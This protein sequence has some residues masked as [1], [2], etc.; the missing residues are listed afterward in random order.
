MTA[1]E[2][3]SRGPS[4][5]RLEP[6]GPG[7]G[8]MQRLTGLD[9]T[10]LYLETPTSHMHVAGCA[11]FDPTGVEDYSFD[12]VK[13]LVASRLHLL[14]PFRRRLVN[15]PFQVHHP[16]W[17]EGPHFDLDYHV[18]RVGLPAPGGAAELAEVAADIMSRPLDRSKPLWEM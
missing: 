2:G 16:L 8:S 9:A 15:V 17:I 14:P 11:V 4:Q 13:E 5:S 7:R 3:W 10:F 12:K 6:T 1:S 18:R